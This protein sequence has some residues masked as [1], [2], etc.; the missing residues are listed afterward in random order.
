MTLQF[1]LLSSRLHEFVPFLGHT[2]FACDSPDEAIT[3]NCF[4]EG[5]AHKLFTHATNL[6]TLLVKASDE[7]FQPFILVTPLLAEMVDELCPE[8]NP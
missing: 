5:S 4:L 6:Q 3:A 1:A 7:I 8:I 2:V